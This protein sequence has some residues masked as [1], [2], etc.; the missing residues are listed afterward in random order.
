M[1]AAL[2]EGFVRQSGLDGAHSLSF[3]LVSRP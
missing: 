1:R 2:L 3:L